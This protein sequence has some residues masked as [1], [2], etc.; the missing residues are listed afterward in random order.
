AALERFEQPV[1]AVRPGNGELFAQKRGGDFGRGAPR[2]MRLERTNALAKRLLKRAADCH[3][4]TDGFHL[5][6]ERGF[7]AWEFLELPFRNFDDHVI[8]RRLE[9]TRRFARDVVGNFVERH[10]ERE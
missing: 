9:G 2:S 3:Y 5:R 8:D 6:G 1:D 4:L 10:S 7:A